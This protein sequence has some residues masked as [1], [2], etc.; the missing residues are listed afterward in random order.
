MSVNVVDREMFSL[1]LMLIV[2]VEPTLN[3]GVSDAKLSFGAFALRIYI[4][5]AHP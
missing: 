2:I 4:L 3:H 1:F 5:L